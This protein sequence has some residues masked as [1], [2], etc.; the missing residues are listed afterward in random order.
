MK[1]DKNYLIWR[2]NVINRDK[3]CQICK[4]NGKNNDGKGLNAHHLIPRNFKM[5]A[6]DVDNGLTLCAGCHTLAKYSA[7]KHPIWFSRWLRIN[8]NPTYMQVINRIKDI[9]GENYNI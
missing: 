5:Y 4:K 3:C 1:R 9:L 7:H 8:R 6:Y 2:E